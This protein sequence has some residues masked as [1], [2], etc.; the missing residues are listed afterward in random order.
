MKQIRYFSIK[1]KFILAFLASWILLGSFTLIFT[2]IMIIKGLNGI[3]NY[4]L[5]NEYHSVKNAINNELDVLLRNV[6]D[7][8]KDDGI[9]NYATSRNEA[10]I[11]SNITDWIPKNF[12]VDLILIFDVKG[13]LVYQYGNFDEFR[14]NEGL[15]SHT[16]IKKIIESNETKGLYFSSKGPAYIASY[17]IMHTDESGPRNGT[18]LYGK[19]LNNSRLEKIKSL[20]GMDLSII[21]KGEVISSTAIGY[22][23]K[24]KELNGFY[25]DLK[26]KKSQEFS[27]YKPNYQTAFVYSI[28]KDAEGKDIGMLEVIRPRKTI[29]LARKFFIRS[30]IW[31]SVSAILAV[32]FIVLIITGLILKP[33]NVLKKTIEEI[34]KTKSTLKRVTIESG[35]EIGILAK[36][37]N[38]MLDTLNKSQN[39]LIKTQQDLIKAEKMGALAELAMGTVH[40]INNPLSIVMGRIQMLQRLLVYKAPIPMVDLD[41][42]LKIIEEQTRRAVEITNSLL[43]YAA[44]ITFRFERC[45]INGLVKDTISLINKQLTE[46]NINIIEN[47]K[48]NLPSLEYCDIHQMR[49]VFMNII[50]NAKQ[51]MGGGGKLEISTDY[52]EKEGIVCIKFIDNGSG[53]AP[54][55][56]NKLFTPFFSTRADGSGLGLA[57]SYNII[58]G[59]HGKIEV[60]SKVGVGS[61]FTIKLP[62]GHKPNDIV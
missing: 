29:P 33:L 21:S 19:L 52:D 24:P 59:H 60:E 30:S 34:Q 44:P 46:E 35:D 47:L 58:K 57:V 16:L 12:G 7:S 62:V 36:E 22:I 9:Y 1:T 25:N 11:K 14:I 28:L 27:I 55:Q 54:E 50:T 39:D 3:E 26:S 32:L 43:R 17:P 42:D 13:D 5:E 23:N 31:I 40:Q 41:K 2:Y 37:F 45:N 6:K 18:Y 20:T 4:Y 10:W 38:A 56:I 15:S 8:A 61:T 48:T 53:V 49:D 51:A